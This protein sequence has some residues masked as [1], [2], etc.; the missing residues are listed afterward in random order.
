MGGHRIGTV[1][2][3]SSKTLWNL[4]FPSPQHWGVD[5]MDKKSGFWSLGFLPDGY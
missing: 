5:V 4:C 3:I 1:S 2:I